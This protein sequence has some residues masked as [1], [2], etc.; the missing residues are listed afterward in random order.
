M[1]DIILIA[2]LQNAI[3][4]KGEAAGGPVM[5]KVMGE[6]PDLRPKAKEIMALMDE[7]LAE[8]NTLSLEQ[9][10]EELARFGV[11]IEEHKKKEVLKGL[12]PLEG[13]EHGLVM[14]FAPGPSGP[15]HIGHSRAAILNDEFCRMQGGKFILRLEDTNPE[16]IDPEAYEMIP[17]DLEDW[18]GV[19]VHETFIQSDRLPI[20]YE[21]ARLLLEKN[22][23]YMCKC[24]VE[25]WRKLKEQRNPCPHREQD[26]SIHLEEF[27]KMLAGDYDRG[28]ISF[29]VKTDITHPNPAVR[30]FVGL[31]IIKETPHPRTGDK[32]FVYPLY[33]FSVAVDDHLMGCTHILRG[34]DHLNNTYRQE[35]V[36]D[37]MGWEKPRFI[38]YGFVS[39]PDMLLKTSSIRAE[40]EQGNFTGW[41][42]T[43][44]GTFRALK[45]R[46]ITAQA[47]RDYWTEVGTK[48]VDIKFAFENLYS[49]NKKLIDPVSNRYFF[50]ADPV[51]V[52]LLIDAPINGSA[53]LYP[54]DP[55]RG[56][57]KFELS[58]VDGKAKVFLQQEDIKLS[59]TGELLRLKDLCN[60]TLEKVGGGYHATY[61]GNDFEQVKGTGRIFQ[62]VGESDSIPIKMLMPDGTQ[63]E[64][65]VEK[66]ILKEQK[67]TVQFERMCFARLES[68]NEDE[69]KAVFTQN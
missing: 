13:V 37:H 30:D 57:R 44:L 21:H 69:V 29:V 11:D 24:D 66:S 17:Q 38:H 47:L 59:N 4:F 40:I 18:L 5:Q 7:V 1:R 34:K 25:E 62:W 64:G 22:A 12:R 33:N 8:V 27:D 15:L 32:Y 48:Q 14:R 53:P 41:D 55:A 45:R 43:R 35:Y 67:D 60:V 65:L 19:K 28:Q 6:N 56:N 23:A 20:Y 31:R 54:A 10:K 46:G 39:I 9:Q 61:L 16:K 68:V 58:P 49:F 63:K 2:A 3:H 42:D 52:D 51:E 26:P 50:V 36:Y